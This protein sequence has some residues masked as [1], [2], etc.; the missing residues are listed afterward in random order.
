M[1]LHE[2]TLKREKT[3]RGC[4]S[5]HKA[6]HG[7]SI[8]GQKVNRHL[9][10]VHVHST[11]HLTMRHSP[12][13]DTQRVTHSLNRKKSRET[14]Q[15]ED[16][17]KGA[18]PRIIKKDDKIRENKEGGHEKETQ[19]STG[20]DDKNVSRWTVGPNATGNRHSTGNTIGGSTHT[21]NWNWAGYHSPSQQLIYIAK[22]PDSVHG[23]PPSAFSTW[24]TM[25]ST[26]SS[27]ESLAVIE[28]ET[29]GLPSEFP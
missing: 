4:N 1:R 15:A 3:K 8:C 20:I 26:Q 16:G 24:S 11:P 7:D 5:R 19:T 25:P 10:R 9:I 23:N 13:T 28:D 17:G 6:S 29:G 22:V 2:H 27:H 14:A 12:N 21:F 18:A